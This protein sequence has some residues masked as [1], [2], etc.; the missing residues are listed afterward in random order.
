MCIN[1]HAVY[2][3]V[4]SIASMTPDNNTNHCMIE[5]IRKDCAHVRGVAVC[6]DR[7]YSILL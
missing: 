6:I 1:G 3:Q 5:T 2:I 4:R 7:Y